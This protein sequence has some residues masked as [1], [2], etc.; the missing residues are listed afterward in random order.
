LVNAEDMVV[1]YRRRFAGSSPTVLVRAPGRVNLIGEHVD[2]N[3][4]MV[5]P[6][7]IDRA[8]YAV[9][10][11]AGGDRVS[12]YSTGP[13]ALA[14]FDLH[15]IRRPAAGSWEA[16]PRGVA[17]ELLKVGA[18]LRGAHLYLDNDLPV[19]AGLSSSAA[20]EMAVA[21]SLLSVAG[22]ALPRLEVSR[23]CRRAE[24][25]YAGVP[26]GIMDQLV[27]GLAE[28]GSVLLIDCRDE[29][30]E[31]VPWPSED[32]VLLV[33]DSR[34]R[35][36]L[37]E[38]TYGE[39]VRQCGSAVEHLRKADSAI[40]SLRDATPERLR[41][42]GSTMTGLIL[43]RARH[44]ITEIDR[45]RAAAEAMRRG[46]FATLGRLMNESHFS[47]R[48]D[49][50]VSSRE[51]DDLTDVVRRV[52]GVFGARLTGAGF[53]GCIVAIAP[54]QTVGAVETAVRKQYD[55]LYG[56]SAEVVVTAP[57]QGATVAAVPAQP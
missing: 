2:Y 11:P 21:L 6:F 48:D 30:T 1:A 35:H 9:A 50:E 14:E 29:R 45:T 34:C 43:R 5:M 46:D 25:N 19:G 12:V 8:V 7:A 20:L 39:R 32:V 16:Y 15:D 40:G 26:C 47:L 36:K 24:H 18:A 38:G 51:L 31:L 4:G 49:Y 37:S 17:A 53:G 10:G 54:R 28:A 52:P 3:G 55:T 44:V 41:E 33:I 57:C 42:C 13:D 27:C 22:V 56:V 23:A